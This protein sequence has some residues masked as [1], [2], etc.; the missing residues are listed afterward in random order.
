MKRHIDVLLNSEEEEKEQ[1]QQQQDG[2]CKKRRR[3]RRL[4]LNNDDDD[5]SLFVCLPKEILYMIAER[6]ATLTWMDYV[7]GGRRMRTCLASCT[8]PTGGF[9]SGNVSQMSER[10]IKTYGSNN[11]PFGRFPLRGPVYPNKHGLCC[12]VETPYDAPVD[13]SFLNDVFGKYVSHDGSI[14]TLTIIVDAL[15]QK[16]P[17]VTLHDVDDACYNL[18]SNGG[19]SIVDEGKTFIVPEYNCF[20]SLTCPCYGNKNHS[21]RKNKSLYTFTSFT[22]GKND[23]KTQDPDHIMDSFR[24]FW[25]CVQR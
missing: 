24:L 2:N 19:F 13:R 17:N 18:S 12:L 20:R 7:Y 8:I 25:L 21:G 1:Q 11:L 16:K 5:Y 9:L 15:K 4:N 6:F 10:E 23:A 22:F 14:K 3:R